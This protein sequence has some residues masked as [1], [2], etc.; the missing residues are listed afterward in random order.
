MR[1]GNH[2]VTAST[3]SMTE[4]TLSYEWHPVTKPI[5]YGL[6]FLCAVACVWVA[7][8]AKTPLLAGISSVFGLGAIL[9]LLNQ[10]TSV[11]LASR[12]VSRELTLAGYRLRS[13]KWSLA[14]FISVGAYRLPAGTPQA[15]ADLVHV[16]L[17]RSSGSILALRYFR[18]GRGRPCPE[19]DAFVR[20]LEE[21]T[22]LGAQAH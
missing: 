21:T 3:K 8:H 16:G 2:A 15:P 14:D 10:R 11:D 17:Q 18:A 6:S 12:S 9:A 7:F 22:Q 1:R 13:S 4:Q 19:A 5:R 20:S